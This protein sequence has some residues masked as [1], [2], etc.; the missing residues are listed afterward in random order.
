MSPSGPKEQRALGRKML[1]HIYATTSFLKK[2]KLSV[3]LNGTGTGTGT[4][5]RGR[6]DAC[7]GTWDSGAR[8]KG[9]RDV[10]YEVRGREIRECEVWDT[11]GSEIQDK[12]TQSALVSCSRQRRFLMFAELIPYVT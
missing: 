6:W 9:L 1:P 11:V 3:P 5:G 2:K 4:W 8:D 7:T 12:G 10:K